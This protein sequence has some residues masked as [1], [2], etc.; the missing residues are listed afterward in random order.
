MERI[1]KKECLTGY[2]TGIY[3]EGCRKIIRNLNQDRQCPRQYLKCALPKWKSTALLVP[4]PTRFHRSSFAPG[5]QTHICYRNKEYHLSPTAKQCQCRCRGFPQKC[6]FWLSLTRLRSSNLRNR[7]LGSSWHF[8]KL[9]TWDQKGAHLTG[10]WL[11]QTAHLDGLLD[12][13]FSC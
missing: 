10:R 4:Q 13:N 2:H 11:G 1:W 7:I 3:L 9:R 8:Q 5:Q 12:R 6:E